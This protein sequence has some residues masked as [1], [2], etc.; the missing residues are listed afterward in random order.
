MHELQKFANPAAIQFVALNTP[1]PPFLWVN[2]KKTG[3]YIRNGFARYLTLN[4]W[5]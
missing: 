4:I 3:D 5:F 2:S 1:T